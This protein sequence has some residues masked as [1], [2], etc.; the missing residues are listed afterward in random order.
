M[1]KKT[2]LY[3]LAVV[4]VA[5]ILAFILIVANDS[6][7]LRWS[8][9]FSN[10]FNQQKTSINTNQPS[11]YI[12]KDDENSEGPFRVVKVRDGDTIEL[13]NGMVIRY[14]YVDTPETVKVGTSVQCFGPEASQFNKDYVYD[15]VV[16]VVKDK[17][18]TDQYGR[19]LRMVFIEGKDSRDPK[20]SVNAELIKLGFAKAKFYSP[21]TK[22]KNEITALEQEAKDKKLGL[23]SACELKKQN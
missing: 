4:L 8:S 21:N 5:S 2:Q 16:R 7:F 20:Q 1:T 12:H 19:Q 6:S 9:S 13:D 15:K 23:W 22:Y 17:G 14:L 11:Q 3:I 10:S 18:D